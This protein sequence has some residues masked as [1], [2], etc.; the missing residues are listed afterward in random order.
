MD[1]S[2]SSLLFSLPSASEAPWKRN[3]WSPLTLETRLSKRKVIKVVIDRRETRE[4]SLNL[5][6]PKPTFEL[7]TFLLT[8]NDHHLA[9]LLLPFL[10]AAML[11]LPL[12]LSLLPASILAAP[13]A[14]LPS[15]RSDIK[16]LT[17]SQRRELAATIATQLFA[18]KPDD[19]V[20]PEIIKAE[21]LVFLQDLEQQGASTGG[22]QKR[23]FGFGDDANEGVLTGYAPA[24]VACPEGQTFIRVAQVSP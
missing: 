10:L 19:Q 16:R 2:F 24:R 11:L 1:S 12:L 9:F 8:S 22:I 18:R 21:V 17:T 23:L 3:T 20:D 14:L 5:R 4:P 7:E 13:S 6:R 15:T